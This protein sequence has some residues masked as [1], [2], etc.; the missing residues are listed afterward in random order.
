MT[1]ARNRGFKVGWM[2]LQLQQALLVTSLVMEPLQPALLVA[3]PERARVA[4]VSHS[5]TGEAQIVHVLNRVTYGVRPGDVERL[6]RMELKKFIEQQLHPE[7]IPD[8]TVEQK[9]AGLETLSMTSPELVMNYPP[10]KVAQALHERQGEA[11]SNSQGKGGVNALPKDEAV[12][13]SQPRLKPGQERKLEAL[14]SRMERN[15]E[16][17]LQPPR[18]VVRELQQAKVL[19]A[20]YS[21][22]QLYEEMVDFWENHFNI[23]AG[24]GADKWLLTEYDRDVIRPNAMGKFKDLVEATAHSPAML[25]YLD[26]WLSADPNAPQNEPRGQGR[27]RGNRPFFGRR[28]DPFGRPQFPGR[29]SNAAVEPPPAG[30]NAK[31]QKRGL[32]ENYARELME[33][34]TMGVEGGYSQKDVTEVARCFTGW[35]IRG[36]RQGG[37]FFFNERMHDSDIKIV[38]GHKIHD[39]GE[40][41]GE[42]VIHILVHHPST[43]H[44]IAKKLVTRFVSDDAPES[45]VRR[46]ADTYL[47]TEGDIRQMLRTIFYSPEFISQDAYRAKVK[48]PFELV[49]S[50]IR[51]SGADTDA[52]APLLQFIARMGQPL[53]LYQ[54]PTGYPDR[55]GEWLNSGT[56]LTRLNF[57]LAFAANK[58]PGTNVD[59]AALLGDAPV[60]QAEPVR[61]RLLQVYLADNVSEQTQS[62]LRQGTDA[63]AERNPDLSSPV[64]VSTTNSKVLPIQTAGLLIGSPEFQRR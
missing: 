48:S 27:F 47:K 1:P 49:V 36:P 56:L 24:K 31:K 6:E 52:S 39:G 30:Q 37:G 42:E 11:V 4:A 64:T 44:F 26:N 58:I 25:F 15:P 40:R 46:V 7:N 2:L 29:F 28:F 16:M 9:L 60:E 50:A 8:P 23:F 20:V 41:D 63:P 3:A 13:P 34:H 32:N 5:L 45:L 18:E 43:A 17:K 33:L 21:E 38:L 54:A 53:F 35:T 55:A 19:R 57:A 59:L 12:N 14:E 62:A 51:T 22:R 10:P 61:L